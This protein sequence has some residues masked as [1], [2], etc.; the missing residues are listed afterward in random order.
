[1][2]L[3]LVSITF[4]NCYNKVLSKWYFYENDRRMYYCW[5]SVGRNINAKGSQVKTLMFHVS[6]RYIFVFIFSCT[7]C[8]SIDSVKSTYWLNK[9]CY[10]KLEVGCKSWYLV[11]KDTIC[12]LEGWHCFLMWY[13]IV[14]SIWRRFSYQES[15]CL[16]IDKRVKV[17]KEKHQRVVYDINTFL[18]TGIRSI[19]TMCE[20]GSLL[21]CA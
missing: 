1:M 20:H 8:R 17:K 9:N 3:L 5:I 10:V 12:N 19:M 6:V 2:I 11:F 13:H 21:N 16:T 7:F 18:N 14:L 4:Y 15:T